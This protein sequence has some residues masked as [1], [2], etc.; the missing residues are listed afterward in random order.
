[1]IWSRPVLR[2]PRIPS[3][4]LEGFASSLEEAVSETC[5]TQPTENFCATRGDL[6]CVV[7]S[8]LVFRHH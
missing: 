5:I 4:C 3:A 2:H 8:E 1:M 6:H 7:V